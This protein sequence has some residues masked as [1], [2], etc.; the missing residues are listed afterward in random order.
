MRYMGI[1][2]G[3]K[4]VG[5]ALSDE[6]LQF[7]LPKVVLP[8][9]YK[10]IERVKRLCDESAVSLIVLGESK[11]YKGEDNA[12]MESITAFMKEVKGMT[13]LQV[14]LEPEFMTSA[15]AGR[16]E[17]R[18]PDSSEGDRLTRG[19]KEKND[20]LDASA[21]ALILKSYLERIKN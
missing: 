14:V 15:E 5:I 1:D 18:R 6:G 21:A 4:R 2:Y 3:S 20:M 12:I 10:L 16:T 7:A 11:N 13:G 8:N 17:F 9:D 19:K